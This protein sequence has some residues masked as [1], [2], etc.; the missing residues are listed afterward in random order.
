ME[1][2]KKAPTLSFALITLIVLIL[3]IIIG[4]TVFGMPVITVLFFSWLVLVPFA[5]YL[6]FT[7]KEIED[8]V[9]EMVKAGI[10]LFALLLAIGC[11]VSIWLCAGTVPT[12]IFWG[13]NL[14]TPKFFLLIA[15]LVCSFVSLPT[16]T[17]WGTIS[18]AGVAMMGVGLGLGL[19]AGMVAGAVVSGAYVGD[20][21]SPVSDTPLLTST[22]CKVPLMKHIKHMLY[23]TVP[24][25]VLTA[26]LFIVLGFKYAGTSLD[27]VTI[28]NLTSALGSTF[29]IGWVTLI[30]LAVVIALLVMRQSAVGSI[31]IGCV[32]GV[33]VA[34]LYQGYGLSDVGNFLAYGFQVQTGNELLDPILNRGGISSML[35]LIGVVVASLGMGGILKGIGILNTLVEALGKVIKSMAGV[36]V[37]TAVECALCVTLV[38]N[39]YFSMIMVG[40]LMTPL[41]KKLK[42]KPENASRIINDW[43]SCGSMFIPFNIGAIFVASTLGVPILAVLPFALFHIIVM[44]LDLIYGLV[45]FSMTKYSDEQWKEALENDPDLASIKAA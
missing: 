28:T 42:L 33:L 24:A 1:K 16:G 6:G 27:T 36:T 11:L 3:F 15:F 9:Y 37:A 21:L 17:S 20:K 23:S 13:L 35:E 25:F 43:S 38:A 14:I 31:M 22:I 29:H 7:T 26:I 10:G 44:A 2:V 8:S 30:P 41:F 45:G 40:T 39:N 4:L 12:L 19:P 32:V 34:T 5:L 18:T